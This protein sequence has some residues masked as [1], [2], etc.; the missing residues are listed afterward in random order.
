MGLFGRK[1]GD[2]AKAPESERRTYARW[3]QPGRCPNCGAIGQVDRIDP[4][5]KMAEHRCRN[6]GTDWVN[7]EEL[8][9]QRFDEYRRKMLDGDAD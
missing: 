6:C 3:M 5:G 2:S 4:K 8:E 1:K 7:S 9:T